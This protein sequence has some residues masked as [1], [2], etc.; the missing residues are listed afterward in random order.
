MNRL[1]YAVLLITLSVFVNAN[2]ANA[3]IYSTAQSGNFY[4]SAT[5]VG[6]V[7]PTNASNNSDTV[8]ISSGHD[9]ILD[10][11]YQM[12]LAFNLLQ[13]DGTLRT[14]TPQTL[15]LSLT[16]KMKVSGTLNVDS[17]ST[18]NNNIEIT[19]QVTVR[20]FRCFTVNASGGGDLTVTEH[21]YLFAS[22]SNTGGQSLT[23]GTNTVLHMMS[24]VLQASGT[25]ILNLGNTYDVVYAGGA[26]STPTG[27]E[28]QGS[29]LRHVTVDLGATE[30]LTLANSLD[31]ANGNL[32]LKGGIFNL[33]GNNLSFTNNGDLAATGSGVLKSTQ[34]S[35]VT[36]ANNTGIS[37][38]LTFNTG[39]NTISTLTLNPA[40][41]ATTALG[42]TLHVSTKVEFL[43]GKMDLAG[44]KLY[45][46]S[47]A[48]ISGADTDKYFI[49]SGTGILSSDI[50]TGVSFT[51][52]IGTATQYAPCTITT[53]SNTVFNDLGMHVETGGQNLPTNRP[54]VNATWYFEGNSSTVDVDVTLMW[55]TAMEVNQ[56]NR[57]MAYICTYY[58]NYWLKQQ[59]HKP[60]STAA[61]GMYSMTRKDV[62]MLEPMAVFDNKTLDVINI[63]TKETLTLYP[64]PVG[65]VLHIG[66][67]AQAAQITIYNSAGA[68]IIN[69]PVDKTQNTINTASLPVGMYF[70]Q[71][72]GEDVD[73]SG[74]I[75][76]Q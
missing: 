29:G 36:I 46:I 20:A 56:F 66:N 74:R 76:K 39:G 53:K 38:P 43:K 41:A 67:L 72:K 16:S 60:A 62:N 54:L 68:V 15:I 11:D 32:T 23:L 47:G 26:F 64:N 37:A 75:I 24:G 49:T 1:L 3:T 7:A 63:A 61:N 52:H 58:N 18:V 73:A 25:G 50:G 34:M 31:M 12:N 44:Y 13:V 2:T 22:F 28:L 65:D 4:S 30:E 69:Q 71:L 8:I 5:W 42:S 19:G 27:P 21:M 51:Y 59:Q 17:L 45:L 70:L 14:T 6:G 55:S 10:N 33:N 57:S 48:T 9:V 35:S 40:N